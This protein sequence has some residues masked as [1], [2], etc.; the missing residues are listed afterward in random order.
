MQNEKIIRPNNLPGAEGSFCR[1]FYRRRTLPAIELKRYPTLDPDGI[2][3]NKE[4]WGAVLPIAHPAGILIGR[5]LSL[6]KRGE[7]YE[8]GQFE[9]QLIT[10][11][12]LTRS[13][14]PPG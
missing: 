4:S 3:I 9:S 14:P 10:N 7:N 11:D 5:R 8:S 2:C 1:I 6:S 12:R 13:T